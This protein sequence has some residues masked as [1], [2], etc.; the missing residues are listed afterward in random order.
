MLQQEAR[1][2]RMEGWCSLLGRHRRWGAAPLARDL[3][4]CI[5]GAY[6][7]TA[8]WGGEEQVR[9]LQK[10]LWNSKSWKPVL[11]RKNYSQVGDEFLAE[12]SWT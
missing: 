2:G 9:Q 12:G 8:S 4:E 7:F 1:R 10:F 3:A 6:N 11:V 5:Q